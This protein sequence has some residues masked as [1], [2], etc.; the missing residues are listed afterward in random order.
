MYE[1]NFV[2]WNTGGE[3]MDTELSLKID[4]HVI[5]L[6]KNYEVVAV[7]L[8]DIQG[9]SH[10]MCEKYIWKN[11]DSFSWSTYF[12]SLAC[13]IKIPEIDATLGQSQVIGTTPLWIEISDNKFSITIN[14]HITI[15]F[16]I[17]KM[18]SEVGGW[19]RGNKLK[20]V[21]R[22]YKDNLAL[23]YFEK[24][25]P[26]CLEFTGARKVYIAPCQDSE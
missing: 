13:L 14:T 12:P 19:I 3:D 11:S 25:Y 7:T 8:Q 24:D 21:F 18:F 6:F 15:C 16:P 2:L 4:E 5:R 22:E 1:L 20:E 23:V 10:G 9:L 17:L 26:L